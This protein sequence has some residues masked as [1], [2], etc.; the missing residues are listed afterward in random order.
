MRAG[1]TRI[2]QLSAGLFA[3]VGLTLGGA[4]VA[5]ATSPSQA[6]SSGYCDYWSSYYD[7]WCYYDGRGGNGD[8]DRFFDDRFFDDRHHHDHHDW[9][10]NDWDNRGDWDD[11]GR[12]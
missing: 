1:T 10:Y 11:R 5:S 2:L 3:A 9:R 4:G 6:P 12:R 7:D 8:R